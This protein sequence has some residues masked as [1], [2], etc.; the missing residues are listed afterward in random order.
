M[1]LRHV[2]ER[3]PDP[4]LHAFVVWGPMLD[5]EERS[6]AVEATRFFD[7]PRSTHFWT[8]DDLLAA[9]FSAPAGLPADELAWDTF[10]L[11]AP[12]QTWGEQP[13]TPAFTMHVGKSLPAE[14]RLHGPTLHD[15]VA[16]RLAGTAGGAARGGEEPGGDEPPS[17]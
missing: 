5:K 4:R 17:P 12:G 1:V 6:D 9:S 15:E 2:F 13:P 7:D 10:L 11:F 8:D 16:A 3:L 14:L